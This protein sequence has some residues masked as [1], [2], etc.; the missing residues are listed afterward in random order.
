M[1]L[2]K[3]STLSRLIEERKAAQEAAKKKKKPKAKRDEHGR[4]VKD[5]AALDTPSM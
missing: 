2:A 3:M 4:F 5:E 1:A